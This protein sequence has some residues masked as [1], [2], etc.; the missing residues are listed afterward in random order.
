MRQREREQQRGTPEC[1]CVQAQTHRACAH[2]CLNMESAA[3]ISGNRLYTSTGSSSPALM[4]TND[5]HK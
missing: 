3:I 5:G 4:G 2:A 1:E